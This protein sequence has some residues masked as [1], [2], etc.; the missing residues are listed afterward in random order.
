MDVF[1]PQLQA[2]GDGIDT[3]TSRP[4]QQAVELIWLNYEASL[5][6]RLNMMGIGDKFENRSVIPII[7]N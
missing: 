2:H 7:D 3:G 1:Q 5:L 6:R 4:A